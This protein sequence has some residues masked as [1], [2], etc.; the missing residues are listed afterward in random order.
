MFFL[1]LCL[2]LCEL[3]VSDSHIR[4]PINNPQEEEKPYQIITY[5]SPNVEVKTFSDIIKIKYL[6]SSSTT[7]V[8]KIS[9][10][11]CE[12]QS[13]T[14]EIIGISKQESVKTAVSIDIIDHLKVIPLTDTIYPNKYVPIILQAYNEKGMLFTSLNGTTIDWSADL[15]NTVEILDHIPND[16][17]IKKK[18]S[19]D[20]QFIVIKASEINCFYLT[21]KMTCRNIDV[22]EKINMTLPIV[23]QPNDLYLLQNTK[24]KMSL[25]YMDVVNDRDNEPKEYYYISNHESFV[26]KTG[27]SSIANISQD[28]NVSTFNTGTTLITVTEKTI[29]VILHVHLFVLYVQMK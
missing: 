16:N 18:L 27:N 24:T 22:T 13:I 3:R 21:C 6:P 28:G 19:N 11:T 9:V 15:S 4:L 23:F 10:S 25:Y 5:S 8:V 12:N 7:T 14:T 20:Q 2:S 29:K 17:S 26:Y 1:F